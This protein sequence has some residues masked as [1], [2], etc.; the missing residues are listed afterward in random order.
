METLAIRWGTFDDP[1]AF[2]RGADA[3]LLRLRTLH[4]NNSPGVLDT[5]VGN[6]PLPSLEVLHFDHLSMSRTLPSLPSLLSLQIPGALDSDRTAVG[7]LLHGSL[8]PRLSH[9][10]LNLWPT[11]DILAAVP[12]KIKFLEVNVGQDLIPYPLRSAGGAPAEDEVTVSER[13]EEIRTWREKLFPSLR[14]VR[15]RDGHAT[16]RWSK[17]VQEHVAALSKEVEGFEAVLDDE[18]W[19]EILP[20][21]WWAE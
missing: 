13:L 8:Y 19:I 15:I 7:S 6:T 2:P 9:L 21:E 18:T 12:R 4:L 10:H 16:F 11:P 1:T 17:R 5:I 14:D 20:R 3:P